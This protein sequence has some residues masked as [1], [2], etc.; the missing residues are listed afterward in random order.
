MLQIARKPILAGLYRVAK[1]VATC[2]NVA[3]GNTMEEMHL[4]KNTA[5]KTRR[6]KSEKARAKRSLRKDVN[7]REHDKGYHGH[8]E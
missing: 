3:K 6:E 4:D 5:R 8:Y 7:K 2:I 1:H